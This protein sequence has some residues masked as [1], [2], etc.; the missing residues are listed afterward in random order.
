MNG[1]DSSLSYQQ[2]SEQCRCCC[3]EL[4]KESETIQITKD[5]QSSFFN[6]FQAEVSLKMI[7]ILLGSMSAYNSAY[8][9]PLAQVVTKHFSIYLCGM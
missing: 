2:D 1:V 9:L 7:C 4:L 5:I 8:F 6:I 3:D